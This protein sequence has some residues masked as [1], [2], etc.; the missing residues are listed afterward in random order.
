MSADEDGLRGPA[1]IAFERA[2]RAAGDELGVAVEYPL[3]LGP[4]VQEPWRGRELTIRW[5]THG[6]Q[7]PATGHRWVAVLL[8]AGPFGPWTGSSPAD[9]PL[10]GTELALDGD[11]WP[12]P[13]RDEVDR[14][15]AAVGGDGALQVREDAV[16]WHLRAGGLDAGRLT[17]AVRVL[18]QV[19]VA[20]ETADADLSARHVAEHPPAATRR[21]HDLRRVGAAVIVLLVVLTVAIRVL[22]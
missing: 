10:T 13:L 6:P 16:L 14:F 15:S 21:R 5:S 9:D 20:A 17:T 11:A 2:L 8:S 12:A 4:W 7:A 18:E 1:G 19:A 22:F 3:D